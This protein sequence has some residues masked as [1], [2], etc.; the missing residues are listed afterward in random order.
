MAISVRGTGVPRETR[1]RVG[2]M[3]AGDTVGVI[4][5]D[6]VRLAVAVSLA[7]TE[8]SISWST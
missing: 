1:G 7:T 5:R 8:I 3:I 6:R 2:V 4:K